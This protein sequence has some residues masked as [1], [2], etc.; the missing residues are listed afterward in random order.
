MRKEILADMENIGII[1]DKVKNENILREGVISTN[2]S[3]VMITVA[4]TDE[5]IIVARAVREYLETVTL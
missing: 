3:P 5:E 1:L 2:D 4:P